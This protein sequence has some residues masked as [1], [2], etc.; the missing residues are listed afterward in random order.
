MKNISL[1]SFL[2]KRLFY[3]SSIA[4]I[5]NINYISSSLNFKSR[6][7]KVNGKSLAC[8]N[9][10]NSNDKRNKN[11]LSYND[12][13]RK[14]FS[15]NI[16]NNDNSLNNSQDNYFNS[17]SEVHDN[18]QKNKSKNTINLNKIRDR[19]SKQRDSNINKDIVDKNTDK[20]GKSS[21]IKTKYQKPKTIYKKYKQIKSELENQS[22]ED[23][24]INDEDEF[25]E[26]Q[27]Y[28]PPSLRTHP[29]DI[30]LSKRIVDKVPA[31]FEE[32]YKMEMV[33]KKEVEKAR[34]EQQLIL[35]KNKELS[36]NLEEEHFCN[37][38]FE[39]PITVD[40]D[41]F[42][43][44]NLY[45]NYI[46]SKKSEGKFYLNID[47]TNIEGTEVKNEK[48]KELLLNL[49][50]L[51][52]NFDVSENT[53]VFQS[54]RKAEYSKYMQFLIDNGSVYKCYCQTFEKC[55]SN[56]KSKPQNDTDFES[57]L[58]NNKKDFTVK[59]LRVNSDNI[60]LKKI[61]DR[62]NVTNSS[63]IINTKEESLPRKGDFVIP[64]VNYSEKV[65]NIYDIGD[66]PIYRNYSKEFSP[67]F[68]SCIDD[69]LHKI[70]NKI[71]GTNYSVEKDFLLSQLLMFDYTQTLDI[72]SSQH[73][74]FVSKRQMHNR[75]AFFK[76]YF[77]VPDIKLINWNKTEFPELSISALRK[78]KILPETILNISFVLG[79]GENPIKSVL[80]EKAKHFTNITE[81][82]ILKDKAIETFKLYDI[83][84]NYA[85]FSTDMLFYYNNR[86]MNFFFF[87]LP[88][89]LYFKST[90]QLVVLEKYYNVFK[91]E[92]YLA[93]GN[94]HKKTLDSWKDREWRK[95]VKVVIPKLK[96]Y[97]FIP[98][99]YFILETPSY[100]KEFTTRYFEFIEK[101]FGT[102][103]YAILFLH[104][105]LSCFTS[106]EEFKAININKK[107]SE[108]AYDKYKIDK[109][110]SI[111]GKNMFKCLKIIIAA[112]HRVENIADI[113]D[114]I[115]KEETINRCK[116][117]GEYLLNN[118]EFI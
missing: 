46:L 65:Y 79:F 42:L 66:F 45:Y 26:P 101:F 17:D 16:N 37:T 108:F 67:T 49:D 96:S 92:F 52:L 95:A 24:K 55:S 21:Q 106:I 33:T 83:Y 86:Y 15:S 105:L 12:F 54:T 62:S 89:I 107:I 71:E 102:K 18:N 60:K 14:N 63:T 31:D 117:F 53:S 100:N 70:T 58:L 56:C 59:Y 112:D 29:V 87:R 35:Q 69:Y 2:S 19:S 8:S 85:Y 23:S 40:L 27:E 88:S 61:Y 30:F 4:L 98:M 94:K 110:N 90:S 114:L 36:A 50:Y 47:D 99:F 51:G 111:T 39:L 82:L 81:Q 77:I 78:K 84:P 48:L 118:S 57:D 41:I 68:R 1:K 97:E 11:T 115:G 113:C 80:Q 93:F 116:L 3:K 64:S 28:I 34:K 7:Y 10:F 9:S 76:K 104:D 103:D 43:L 91:K 38:Y 13:A 44:R 5:K 6:L 74:N 20:E 75:L 22:K 109:M 32:K 25:K 72:G 73:D